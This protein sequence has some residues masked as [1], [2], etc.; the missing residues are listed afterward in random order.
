MIVWGGAHLEG[1][2]LVNV[3]LKTGGRYNPS[4]DSWQPTAVH[5]AP[6]RRLYGVAVWADEEMI[7]WGGGDQRS[8]NMSTGG[9]YNPVTDRWVSTQTTGA[10]SGRS[11]AT[12]VW[13]GD[14]MLIFGGST[15]GVEAFNETY[16]YQPPRVTA[17]ANR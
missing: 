8:G 4:S 14:G 16:Y 5:D 3:G 10:P 7:V 1:D 15:G 13:T 6:D 9:R 17:G 12:A 2:S 11:I